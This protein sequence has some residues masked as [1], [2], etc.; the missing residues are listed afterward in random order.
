MRLS[1]LLDGR[2]FALHN[3]DD[4]VDTNLTDPEG[5]PRALRSR[6]TRAWLAIVTVLIAIPLLGCQVVDAILG[7]EDPKDVRARQ[8]QIELEKRRAKAV[9]KA[10]QLEAGIEQAEGNY[11]LT[12]TGEIPGP[13]GSF[14]P[15]N[16]TPAMLTATSFTASEVNKFSSGEDPKTAIQ[17]KD[18]WV[19]D[20]SRSGSKIEGSAKFVR[21]RDEGTVVKTVDAESGETRYEAAPP[22][23]YPSLT[24]TWDGQI[25]AVVADDGTVAGTVTGTFSNSEGLSKPFNWEFTGDPTQ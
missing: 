11:K 7:S 25:K 23:A 13:W 14:D 1:G 12:F 22:G 9:D 20:A 17:A 16:R 4:N 6:S 5:R 3:L 2:L 21:W 18:T 10:K 8:E 24:V 19:I 15:V